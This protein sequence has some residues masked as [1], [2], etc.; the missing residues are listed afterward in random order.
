MTLNF[1]QVALGECSPGQVFKMPEQEIRERLDSVA[2]DSQGLFDYK[3]SSATQHVIMRGSATPEA[4]LKRIYR[5][6]KS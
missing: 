3:E 4:L 1:G 5:G 6:G 2:R